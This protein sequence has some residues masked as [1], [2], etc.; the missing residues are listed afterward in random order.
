ML[1]AFGDEALIDRAS[2]SLDRHL[3][4]SS[5]SSSST[6][7]RRVS[8]RAQST[9]LPA[10]TAATT[11]FMILHLCLAVAAS[12]RSRSSCVLNFGSL[13]TSSCWAWALLARARSVAVRARFFSIARMFSADST[14]ACFSSVWREVDRFVCAI[15]SVSLRSIKGCSALKFISLCVA[16][17]RHP[18]RDSTSQ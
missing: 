9:P 4:S 6:R 12:L 17:S 15:S 5:F 8:S 13:V 10:T 2:R 3:Q 1:L 7:S 18:A 11:L 16:S 14:P